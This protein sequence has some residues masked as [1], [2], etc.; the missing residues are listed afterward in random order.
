MEGNPYII[1]FIQ[2]WWIWRFTGKPLFSAGAFFCLFSGKRV[3]KIFIV[4]C[5][6][7]AILTKN[8]ALQMLKIEKFDK[9]R[10]GGV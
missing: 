5:S 1:I 2:L 3:S 6:I 7:S 9:A 10:V 8:K 4:K